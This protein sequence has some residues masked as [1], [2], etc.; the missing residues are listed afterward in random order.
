MSNETRYSLATGGGTIRKRILPQHTSLSADEVRAWARAQGPAYG[1]SDRAR[2][3]LIAAVDRALTA[4]RGCGG[5]GGYKTGTAGGLS[6]VSF[7]VTTIA[8][9]SATSGTAAWCSAATQCTDTQAGEPG[10][11]DGRRADGELDL[12][13]YR[14][15]LH[16]ADTGGP[17]WW[18]TTPPATTHPRVVAAK[19]MVARAT[20]ALGGTTPQRRYW[21]GEG[22]YVS[23]NPLACAPISVG[24]QHWRVWV[25]AQ[26]PH[27]YRVTG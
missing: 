9:Q 19:D 23:A 2:S 6:V 14:H 26:R 22:W 27:R 20:A 8:A 10:R 11:N 4:G 25:E 7:E 13:D 1:L 21:I 18:T 12:A 24:D 3:V 16:P 15:W 17:D 5:S